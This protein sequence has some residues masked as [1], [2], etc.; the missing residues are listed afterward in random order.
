MKGVAPSRSLAVLVAVL[1]ASSRLFAQDG[2]PPA[3]QPTSAREQ[4]LAE[5]AVAA[6][7]L[8]LEAGADCTKAMATRTCQGMCDAWQEQ[9]GKFFRDDPDDIQGFFRSSVILLGRVRDNRGVVGMYNP[10][11][12]GVLLTAWEKFAADGWKAVRFVWMSG[13][14]FRGEDFGETEYCPVWVG[15]K[16][17]LSSSVIDVSNAT[18]KAF[19]KRF[20]IDAPF[21]FPA[22]PE[23]KDALME[24]ALVQSRMQFRLKCAVDGDDWMEANAPVK[25]ALDRLGSLLPR[26]SKEGIIDLASKD[27]DAIVADSIALIPAGV[28]EAFSATW[29]FTHEQT[30]VIVLTNPITPRWFLVVHIDS[31]KEKP[32]RSIEFYDFEIMRHARSPEQDKPPEKK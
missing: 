11:L 29:V 19:E 4:E 8:R 22:P 18:A 2:N 32:I 21:E 17:P 6:D 30:G 31:S 7:F 12:D 5:L 27:Q 14:T 26:A 3:K 10:W 25:Q 24:L 9:V 23:P 1:V 20:P 13:A 15:K 16:G 28:R